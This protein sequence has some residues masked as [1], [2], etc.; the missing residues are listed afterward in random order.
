VRAFLEPRRDV[1]RAACFAVAGPARAGV[2][3]TTNLP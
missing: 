2:A 3:V 1:V